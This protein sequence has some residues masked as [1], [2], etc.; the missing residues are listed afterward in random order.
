M[1]KPRK[2]VFEHVNSALNNWEKL[3][4]EMIETRA[5]DDRA[6]KHQWE[7]FVKELDGAL[8]ESLGFKEITQAEFEAID[9]Q[10]NR[11]NSKV[12]SYYGEE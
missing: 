3:I 10:I 5:R 7:L 1:E 4:D 8:E 9:S 6:T 12:Y 2:T 11:I